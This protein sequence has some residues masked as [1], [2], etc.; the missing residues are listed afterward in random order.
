MI[1]YIKYIFFLI[2][3][4]LNNCSFDKKSGIWSGYEEEI[5]RVAELESE[6][7]IISS[8]IIT[9]EDEFSKVVLTSRS[10]T[11]DSPKNNNSWPMSG[12]NLQNSSGNLYFPGLKSIFLK[13]KVGKNKFNFYQKM[14]SPIFFENDLVVSDDV[15]SIKRISKQGKVYWKVRIYEK[16]Y[17]KL[18]KNLTFALH[19]SNI[20]V[21]DNIG[22][23]YAINYKNGELIWKK[24]FGVPFKSSLKILNNKIFVINQDNRILC[25]DS[26]DG[27][28]IWDVATIQTFIKSQNLLGL[29]IT[30]NE[31][32]IALNT[33]GDVLKINGKIGHI[34]WFMNSLTSTSEH[35][36]DFFKSSDIVVRGNDVVFSSVSSTFSLNLNNGYINWMA[37]PRSSNTPI[38]AGNNIFLV[39]DGGFFVNLDRTTGKIVFSTN[40]LKVLKKK[41]EGQE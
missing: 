2:L 13:K 16:I 32:L 3:I 18:Y 35:E 20:Y 1:K 23:V 26:T 25:L 33:A 14:Q 11:L 6:S 29:A 15:G 21:A 24:N 37:K 10:I 19:N 40:I 31:N 38:I 22:F 4:L 5:K 36:T 9:S 28:V 17:K 27:S 12:L 39:T 8:K 34:I 30:K 41:R 7:K